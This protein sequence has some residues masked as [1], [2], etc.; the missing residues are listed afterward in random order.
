MNTRTSYA[1]HPVRTS[2]R[3]FAAAGAAQSASP[4]SARQSRMSLAPAA[5]GWP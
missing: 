2:I 1:G 5:V 4:Q 3:R